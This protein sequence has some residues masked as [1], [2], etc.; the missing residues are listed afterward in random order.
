MKECDSDMKRSQDGRDMDTSSI[1][2][3]VRITLSYS[4]WN[5]VMVVIKYRYNT[6][7]LN[8]LIRKRKTTM[9][10]YEQYNYVVP[11]TADG[12]ADCFPTKHHLQSVSP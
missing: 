4:F 11:E 3:L 6:L 2:V 1:Q 12:G 9:Q 8:L 7:I 5:T 10:T